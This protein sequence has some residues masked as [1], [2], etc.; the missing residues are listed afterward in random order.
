LT[1]S[2]VTVTVTLDQNGSPLSGWTVN[3]DVFTKVFTENW[4]GSI[5]FTSTLG[6]TVSTGISVQNILPVGTTTYPNCDTPDITFSGFTIAACNVGASKA[7]TGYSL[8]TS[9]KKFQRGNN[10]GWMDNITP[11][12]LTGPVSNPSDMF[13]TIGG[14]FWDWRTLKDDTLR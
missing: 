5:T 14:A 2:G 11:S 3:G 1:N 9:G 10:N 7:G 6:G 8:E 13:I 12:A 4:S